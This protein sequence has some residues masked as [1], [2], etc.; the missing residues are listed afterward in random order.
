MKPSSKEDTSR[1]ALVCKGL[2]YPNKLKYVYF[3]YVYFH[4]GLA[5]TFFSES[6]K[7]T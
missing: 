4:I 3:V 7:G 5:R 2:L 6:Q 1:H